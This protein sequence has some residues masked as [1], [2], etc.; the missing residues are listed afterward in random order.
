[1]TDDDRC[2]CGQPVRYVEDHVIGYHDGATLHRTA[3]IL[4]VISIGC[5]HD[6]PKVTKASERRIDQAIA[7]TIPDGIEPFYEFPQ[8]DA[9]YEDLPQY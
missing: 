3:I 4:D 2:N 1:M 9:A 8:D 6:I 5:E 7:D